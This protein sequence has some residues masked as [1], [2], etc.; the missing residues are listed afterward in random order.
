MPATFY[1]AN[2]NGLSINKNYE[3]N[4]NNDFEEDFNNDFEKTSTNKASI[5]VFISVVGVVD[6]L[7]SAVLAVLGST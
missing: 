1:G 5:E 7:V 4:F 6:F 3:K 2:R